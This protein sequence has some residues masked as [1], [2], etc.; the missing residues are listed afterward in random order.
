MH[1]LDELAAFV[2]VMESGSL[3]QSARTLG[4]AKSTL[5]RRINQLES[6]LSQPLLRRQANRL[7]PTEAGTLFHAYS[8]Q[9]LRLAEQ[10]QQAL[11]ALREEV[12]GE[13]IVYT[14]EGFAR[15][16]LAS[17]MEA[18][19]ERYPGIRLTLRTQLSPPQRPEDAPLCLWLGPPPECGLRQENLGIMRRGLYAHPAYLARYG[20]P[21]HPRQLADHA[22]VDL[23]REGEDG[24]FLQHADEGEYHLIPPR[25]WLSVDQHA[26][27]IDAIARGKGIGIMPHWMAQQRLK[28]HPDTLTRCLEAW[29]PAPLPVTLLYAFGR[30]PCK[31]STLLKHLRQSI[32]DAWRVEYSE[33]LA[34]SNTH[35]LE[36]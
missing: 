26:L 33:M 13:L 28:H 32:P 7:I 12:S 2:A 31:V 27:H 25:T 15:G 10:A 30:Q 29:H 3:T 36:H 16:W 19:A 9:I 22:W 20:T 23:I 8:Q 14:H 5:S 1:D 21:T 34:Q 18:F 35:L 24:V 4:V 17:Q 6:R 11:E